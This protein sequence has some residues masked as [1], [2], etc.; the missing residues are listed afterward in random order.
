M[1]AVTT[2][3][4]QFCI[5]GQIT[6]SMKAAK[7][8]R[9]G[10]PIPPL[11]FVIVMEYLHRKLEK[12]KKGT[13]FKYHSNCEKIGLID[14][15][16]GDDLLLFL[17]GFVQ[18]VQVLTKAFEGFSRSTWLIVNPM[19]CKAYYGGIDQ[20]VQDQL[21]MVTGFSKGQLPFKYLGVPLMS[22]RI[23]SQHYTDLCDK[24]ESRL[25]HWSAH[26]LSYAGRLQLLQSV[27]FGV[28]NYWMQCIPIPMSVIHK[29]E[30]MCRTY[31]LTGKEGISRKS[32]ISWAKV[33]TPKK[34][35]GLSLVNLEIWNRMCMVRLLWN[36]CRK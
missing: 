10:D 23:S 32:P 12:L 27:I 33:C 13:E 8:L 14:L 22:R 30:G 2:V 18:S 17:K 24:V 21:E 7:G 11:L 15:S 35:G 1:K 16:F 25:K 36:L 20:E 9:Q 4:Y 5:N 28:T 34:K 19:K 6:R 31:F 3:S 26:L 29:I